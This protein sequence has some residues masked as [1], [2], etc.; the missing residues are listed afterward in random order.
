MQIMATVTVK[1]RM[2]LL[3]LGWVAD[4]KEFKDTL[5]AGMRM[6]KHVLQPIYLTLPPSPIKRARRKSPVLRRNILKGNP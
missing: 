4:V 5:Q 1:Y 6:P 2:K 3:P